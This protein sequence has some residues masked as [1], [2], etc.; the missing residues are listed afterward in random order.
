MNFSRKCES[1]LTV[2]NISHSCWKS[3]G[4]LIAQNFTII[5]YSLLHP[6]HPSRYEVAYHRMLV[7]LKTLMI[8]TCFLTIS[9]PSLETINSNLL[10]TLCILLHYKNILN[11]LYIN[12]FLYIHL[13]A[14]SFHLIYP[15]KVFSEAQHF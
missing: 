8:F 3:M 15:L 2:Y 4:V 14:L 6:S 9:M 7:S 13:H 5:C 10:I 1:A 11:N 12:S